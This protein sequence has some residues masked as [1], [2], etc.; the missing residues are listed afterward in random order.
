MAFI[1]ARAV[2]NDIM[3]GPHHNNVFTEPQEDD[4]TPSTILVPYVF[5]DVL[6]RDIRHARSFSL[7]SLGLSSTSGKTP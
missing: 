1:R 6:R 7:H 5:L 3:L 2:L 4:A